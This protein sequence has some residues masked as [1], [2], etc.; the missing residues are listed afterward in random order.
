ME[1]I[2][3]QTDARFFLR[4]LIPLV[5]LLS[6]RAVVAAQP[7]AVLYPKI[8][9][10]YRSVF[11]S[12]IRGIDN[13]LKSRARQ[14]ELKGTESIS[15]VSK[16]LSKKR[17]EVVIALG[18]TGLQVAQQL[19]DTMRLVIGAVLVDQSDP[20][21]FSGITLATDPSV[22]FERLTSLAPRVKRVT[23]VYHPAR[24]EWLVEKARI[25]ASQNKLV[26]RA[27]PAT[28]LS[29]S[30]SIYRK[31]L[32][33]LNR[34]SEAVW[35]LQDRSTLDDQAILPLILST[36]WERNLVVISNNPAHVK[37]GALFSLFPDNVAMGR[38]LGAMAAK[39]SK[40]NAATVSGVL[41]LRDVLIAVNTRTAEHLGLDLRGRARDEFNLT[42]P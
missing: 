19:P 8:R 33:K 39:L 1:G 12:I 41:P 24:N 38:S 17:I 13:G 6:V 30:A 9:E 20:S 2:R 7:V 15:E 25:A 34:G 26:L 42:Y 35:L 18:T 16:W 31:I 4:C 11:T 27:L 37:R 10:P 32:P 36:A 29:G 14:L 5:L 40:N 21:Q 28:D 23:V 22:L 3:K